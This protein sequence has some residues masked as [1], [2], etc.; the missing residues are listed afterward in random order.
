MAK[1]VQRLGHSLGEADSFIGL[2]R[3][4]TVD[5]DNNNLRLHDG[6]TV[7]GNIIP[8]K[9]Y[10]D[11][12]DN[13]LQGNIDT[14]QTTADNALSVANAAIPD[15]TFNA[16]NQVIVSSGAAA[17]AALTMGASTILA[18]LSAGNV[19]A[20]TPSQIR[21]LLNLVVGTD[22]QAWSQRLDEIGALTAAENSFIVGQPGGGFAEEDAATARVSMGLGTA[23]ELSKTQVADYSFGNGVKAV[24]YQAAAPAFWTQDASVNDQVIRVV[25]TPGGGN[26]GSWNVSGFQADGHALTIAEMPAHSFRLGFTTFAEGSGGT[27]NA[28]ENFADPKAGD[29]TSDTLG[30]NT[31]HTHAVSN[32]GNW[33]PAYIDCI[34]CTKDAGTS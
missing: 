34:V 4:I 32:D 14:A 7:G 3:E 33:R 23:A 26:G 21:S 13:V 16:D 28:I 17:Y 18:R 5:V 1:R 31:P 27:K 6:Q 25:N 15:A 12:Q 2:P 20:A 30:S 19:V 29:K 8:N 10:V 22:V 24:F 11:G 9:A